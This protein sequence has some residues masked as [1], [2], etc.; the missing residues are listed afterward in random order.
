MKLNIEKEL[1]C[2]QDKKYQEFQKGLCPG[3][4]NII[5]IRVPI[6]RIGIRVPILRD[7]AKE[8]LKKYDFKKLM[9]CINDNYYEET[10]LQGMLI[11]GAKE[12]FDI[13]IKY[14]EAFIPKINNWAVC[15]TFCTGLKI[16][17]KHKDEMWLFLQKYL[18]SKKEF[19]V[20]FGI[21][22]ILDYFIDEEHLEENFK[23]FN[24]IKVDKYYVQMAVAWAISICLI[25]NYDRTVEYL[26]KEAD[27]DNFT[28]NKSIQKATESYRITDKQ[29]DFLRS[30]KK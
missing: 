2:L 18:K 26:Q 28:Y 8:L 16:T 27:L 20:R 3:I 30:I 4:G 17:K 24:N 11:G 14:I 15:D 6:L 29:K 25:K 22:M 21:V 1:F 10:M 19:E 23:I 12:E 5:G 9:E 13:I 7:Y